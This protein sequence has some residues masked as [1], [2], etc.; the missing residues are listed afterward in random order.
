MKLDKNSITVGF[1][2]SIHPHSG[3]HIKTLDVMD[4]ID[5]VRLY[6][7][8]G[9]DPLELSK[10][11]PKIKIIYNDLAD[12]IN[13]KKIDV[14]ILSARNDLCPE[15]LE[16]AAT[17]KKHVLFDKPGALSSKDL[18]KAR[19]I[20]NKNNVNLSV[21]FLNR[22]RPEIQS[23]RNHV[24]SGVFGRI[25]SVEARMI[26]SQVRYRDPTYWLFKKKFGG[27]GILS[28]LGC[29]YIDLLC[30]VL[31]ERVTEVSAYVDNLN[32]EN[33]EV[34]D[35]AVL[36]LKFSNGTLGSFQN[37]YHIAGSV[38]G[39]A[40]AS[41]DNHLAVRGVKGYGTLP[42][43]GSE[44]IFYSEHE[45]LDL[46]GIQKM[47]FSPPDSDAYGGVAGERFLEDF[48]ISSITGKK[49][50][51]SIESIIHVLEVIE[52]ALESSRTSRSI[53]I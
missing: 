27:A 16:L 21:M 18:Y 32:E 7:F 48:I 35:T 25:M 47:Q 17:A 4:S 1:I 5:E 26:T 28:W 50:D 19:D 30:Y 20:A 42:F 8:E 24:L 45:S 39:Y 13:D 29:H 6:C 33:L 2:S 52:S 49:Y 23:I 11:S 34:E 36:N 10:I 40:G 46:N 3:M 51:I 53:I 14:I 41:S 43:G 37:G 38:S 31:G 44:Y 12:L 9:Q 22:Y 15:I